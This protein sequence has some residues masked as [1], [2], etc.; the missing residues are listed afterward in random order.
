MPRN[1]HTVQLEL[2]V[3]ASAPVRDGPAPRNALVL[4]EERLLAC[5]HCGFC[6][7]V[8]P[9]YTRLGDE[10]DSPRGRLYLMRAVAEGRIEP[11]ADAFATHIDRC[12]GC[13]ACEPVCPS[14]VEFGFLLER[15]RAVS[16]AENGLPFA[17]RAMLTIFGNRLLASIAGLAG[18]VLRLGGLAGWLARKLAPRRERLGFAL[19]MLAA[20][21]PFR[22]PL[23]HRVRNPDGSRPPPGRKVVTPAGPGLI[24]V[25]RGESGTKP[26]VA[27]LEGCVQRVLFGHVNHATRRVLA[28]AGYTVARA[29]GQRCCGALH[30]HAGDLERAR[31]LALANI[32]AFEQ[33]GA[34]WVA[35]NAAGCAAAMKKYGELFENTPHASR[36]QEFGA[37]VKDVSELIDARPVPGEPVSRVPVAM[38]DAPRL[39][40]TYD[41]PCHLIH[42]QGIARAPIDKL[43]RAA[44]WIEESPLERAEECCGGAGLYGFTHAKLGR[45]IGEDKAS[46]VRATN[47][48]I[49]LTANAGCLMQIGACLILAGD[50]TPVMHAV[51]LLDACT[52]P[53]ARGRGLK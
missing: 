46:A 51:D 2:P 32:A 47:A 40:V 25:H 23:Q 21:R 34:E 36:A 9:T 35:V 37:R 27:I 12:L 31:R 11:D 44:P 22:D 38:R 41:A 49:V 30:A 50:Q 43:L 18:R 26:R 24:A 19:A 3:A 28:R 17:P 52:G 1:S 7:D 39:S 4:E 5:V 13:R 6:Q 8:C 14:G 45:R 29:P 33:S 15:A 16:L 10:L 20:T 53:A 42:A 48:D